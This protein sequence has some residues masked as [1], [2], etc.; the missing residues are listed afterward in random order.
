M[1]VARFAA[2]SGLTTALAVL[3]AGL[4]PVVGSR[5]WAGQPAGT[6]QQP[7]ANPQRLEPVIVLQ[8]QPLGQM[9]GTLREMLRQTGNKEDAA[10]LLE[11]FDELLK[12]KLG[13]K[14]FTG[15]DLNR[16]W[17]G[18]VHLRDQLNGTPWALV[19]PISNEKDFV[20]L[21]GRLNIKVEPVA[22]DKQLYRLLDAV[23]SS[24]PAKSYIRCVA[25]QWAYVMFNIAQPWQ[26]TVLPSAE[27]LWQE[28]PEAIASL[29]VY[30]SRVPAKLV[31]DLSRQIED[32]AAEMRELFGGSVAQP[33]LVQTVFTEGSRWLVRTLQSLHQQGQQM[34][35]VLRWD[36][37][38]TSSLVLDTIVHPKA[39]TE[40]ATAIHQRGESRQRFARLAQIEKTAMALTLQLPQFAPEIRKIMGLMVQGAEQ[41]IEKEKDLP[42]PLAT[43]IQELLRR[44]QR[45]IQAANSEL[46]LLIREP[47]AQGH[48]SLVLAWGCGQTDGVDKALRNL[49]QTKPFDQFIQSEGGKG[50]DLSV[51]QLK[52]WPLLPAEV[53]DRGEQVLGENPLLYVACGKD[54]LYLAA[55]P[56]AWTMIQVVNQLSP[57]AG[58][59]C[60]WHYKP[61]HLADLMVRL[62]GD[63][64]VGEQIRRYLGETDRLV[65][66]ARLAADGGNTLR[67]RCQVHDRIAFALLHESIL[68]WV[69]GQSPSP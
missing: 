36:R 49:T 20:D 12:K 24:D 55:G 28:R 18:L 52:V 67:L 30:P 44:W 60:E 65:I 17:G 62:T 23:S 61:K 25:D 45:D 38:E 11:D 7:A 31:K 50:R 57:G 34:E 42:P 56:E 4:G 15:I 41:S 48:Y 37:S 59:A 32:A 43:L 66:G 40:L 54:A 13:D 63:E 1:T 27:Q 19:V 26:E 10:R 53:R 46:A 14:G 51:Y 64:E 39:G 2:W 3:S 5:G 21:L 29:R 16:P 47:N 22:G 35:T 33:Q 58:G 9:L 68:S 8:F 6:Q 69:M